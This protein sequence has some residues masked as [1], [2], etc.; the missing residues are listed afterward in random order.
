MKIKEARKTVQAITEIVS[1][2]MPRGKYGESLK[3]RE[4][5]VYEAKKIK[6]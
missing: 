3:P 1:A 5:L 4:I 6:C 2:T